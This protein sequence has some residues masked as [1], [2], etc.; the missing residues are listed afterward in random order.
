MR[1]S[2]AIDEIPTA[3]AKM[4]MTVLAAT[5]GLSNRRFDGAQPD[6][7]MDEQDVGGQAVDDSHERDR[8]PV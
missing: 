3:R 2:C 5:R 6:E 1:Y 7:E 8:T 4:A